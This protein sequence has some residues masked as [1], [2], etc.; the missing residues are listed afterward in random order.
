MQENCQREVEKKATNFQI[1][2]YAEVHLFMY[3]EVTPLVKS[4]LRQNVSDGLFIHLQRPN[5]GVVA[6][7]TDE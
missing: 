6:A 3:F 7:K 1:L 2:L 5:D 4:E